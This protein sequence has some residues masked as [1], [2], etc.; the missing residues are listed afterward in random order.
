MIMIDE[1]IQVNSISENS[2]TRHVF[3]YQDD[4]KT[5]YFMLLSVE[6]IRRKLI[7]SINL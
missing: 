6:S 1:H 5:Y 4:N 7:H 2:F 3:D